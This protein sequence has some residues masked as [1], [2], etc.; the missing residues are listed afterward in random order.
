M[1][2]CLIIQPAGLGDIFFVQTIAL[3]YKNLG[4]DVIFPIYP[5]LLWINN[6]INNGINFISN[7]DIFEMKEYYRSNITPTVTEE[8]VILPLGNSQAFA[9]GKIMESKYNMV[10]MDYSTWTRGFSFSRNIAKEN[11]LYYNVLGL[12]DSEEYI[13]VNRL[14]GTPPGTIR[15]PHINLQTNKKIIE[16]SLVEGFTLFDWCKVLELASEIHMID[17][18]LNYIIDKL[19]INAKVL[20][21]YSR[22]S[23]NFSEV[24]YI[25]K[26]PWNYIR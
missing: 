14:Y 16:L 26:K 5:Q 2:K 11:E 20:N 4:F 19:V 13:F 6:Y 7:D 1:K 21:S 17:T 24:D 25:F 18:S 22:R 15:Y 9:P 12:H 10:N 23:G 3:Y 8:V